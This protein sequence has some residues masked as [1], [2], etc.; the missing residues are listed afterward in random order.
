MAEEP[1]TNIVAW[2]GAGDWLRIFSA[3]KMA[4]HPTKLGLALAALVLTYC[5]GAVLD[6]VWESGGR[7]VGKWA[8]AEF[9]AG[10]KSEGLVSSTRLDHGIGEVWRDHTLRHIQN[11]LT[12]VVTLNFR[13]HGSVWESAGM[14]CA[15]VR[16]MVSQHLLFALLFFLGTLAIWSLLG[17][18]ICRIAAVQF[19]REEKIGVG[20][21]L[22]FAREKF[23]SG[24]FVS[25]LLPIGMLLF[26]ALLLAIGGFVL[27]IPA[28]GNLFSVLF[29]LAIVGGLAIAFLL[30]GCVGGGSFFWPTVAVEGSDGFDAISR[31]FSY[32][33]SRPVKTIFYG[34]TALVWGSI[35]WVVLKVILWMALWITHAC[36]GFGVGGIGTG[37]WGMRS[38]AGAGMTKLDVLW[39]APSFINLWGAG[40]PAQRG[41]W[42]Y[43][44]A[45]FIG[46]WV[47]LAIGLLWAFLASYYFSASTIIYYLLRHDVDATDYEDVYVVEE[48]EAEVKQAALT[49][50]AP[51]LRTPAPALTT[52]APAPTTPASETP[53]PETP[54]AEGGVSLPV[55]PPPPEGE[56]PP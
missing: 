22:R 27:W 44:A 56:T 55:V 3:T 40:D 17:T 51:A 33:F 1:R 32:F 38:G 10:E 15:G 18:A 13:G 45:I 53:P 23:I 49:T 25:P 2:P 19:A 21:A 29:G 50:P 4:L 52:P 34:L 42:E 37:A 31:S 26:F 54:P 36:V 7:G 24:F 28:I 5:W 48:E 30:I 35:C 43:F 6:G 47:V 12:G 11:V 39:Q 8:I 16:W 46:L 41:G 14:L 20:P 9:A